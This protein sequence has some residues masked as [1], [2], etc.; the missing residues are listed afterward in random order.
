MQDLWEIKVAAAIRKA[1]KNG[2]PVSDAK[3]TAAFERATNP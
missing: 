1:K 3:V 2:K